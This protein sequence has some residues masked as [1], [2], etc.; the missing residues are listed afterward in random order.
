M[1]C[2]GALSDTHG[3]F[4]CKGRLRPFPLNTAAIF[5]GVVTPAATALRLLP[6]GR[7]PTGD[8][9]A[10]TRDA[11]G[12][13]SAFSLRVSKALAALA[14]QAPLWSHLRLHRHSQAAEFGD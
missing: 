8:V 5:R 2:G 6:R 14:L 11:P 7:A 10:P 9:G 3:R 4:L 13:V 12:G 1:A